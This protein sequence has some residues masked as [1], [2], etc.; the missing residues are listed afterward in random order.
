MPS[1]TELLA[2]QKVKAGVAKETD[3]PVAAPISSEP[4]LNRKR[5]WLHP[6]SDKAISL[7]AS[8]HESAGNDVSETTLNLGQFSDKVKTST[9]KRV[10]NDKQTGNKE[11]T[12]SPLSFSEHDKTGHKLPTNLQQSSH[13]TYN[14]VE[15]NPSQTYNE[16]SNTSEVR[17]SKDRETYN[18]VPTEL[19][20]ASTTNPPQSSHKLTTKG[21]ILAL[22]GLQLELLIFIYDL[23]KRSGSRISDPIAISFLASFCKTTAKSAQESIRRL[24]QKCFLNREKFKNGRGGWTQYSIPESVFKELSQLDSYNK[25]PTKLPQTTNKVP[26]QLT[27]EPPTSSPIVVVSSNSINTT[28]TGAGEEPC[29]V[30]P[31]DLTGKVSRRQLSEFVLNGKITESDLQLSLDAFAYDLKHKLVSSKYSSNPVSLLIGAIKNN[32]SYNS[33]KYIELLKS[34]LRPFVLEQRET[35]AEKNN[36]KNSKE[37]EE[38]QKFKLETQEDYKILESKVSNYGFTGDLLEEFT[39]LEFKKVILK[40]E[41]EKPINPL[42]PPASSNP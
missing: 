26:S 42:R 23:C 5:P 22:T 9:D 21:D 19:T 4:R 1:L 38:F 20:T 2:S 15:A 33:A 34:E 32:G 29:F 28:N 18:K 10:A 31:N 8:A 13:E 6:E 40:I 11:V 37:W 3:N 30:I 17:N 36:Q 7:E 16:T 24:Q 27:T 14:K 12:E 25:L 39:F 35:T 41:N